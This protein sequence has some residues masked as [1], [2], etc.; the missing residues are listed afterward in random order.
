MWRG[1]NPCVGGKSRIWGFTSYLGGV[2]LRGWFLEGIF[3]PTWP[4]LEPNVSKFKNFN[5]V[6]KT[7]IDKY[8]IR[9]CSKHIPLTFECEPFR[10]VSICLH[11]LLNIVELI[12]HFRWIPH[13]KLSNWIVWLLYYSNFFPFFAIAWIIPAILV[14]LADTRK[15]ARNHAKFTSDL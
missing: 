14:M 13:I 5:K 2:I 11:T 12:K 4:G 6:N 7:L 3:E 15:F 1:F 8:N 9:K 10:T